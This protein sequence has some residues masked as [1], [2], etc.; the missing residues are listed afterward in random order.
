[1]IINHWDP[2]GV[3][4]HYLIRQSHSSIATKPGQGVWPVR[5]D[6]PVIS[7][8][9]AGYHDVPPLNWQEKM[10]WETHLNETRINPN[11][12]RYPGHTAG[13]AS[14][15]KALQSKAL[16]GGHV[17]CITTICA[18]IFIRASIKKGECFMTLNLDSTGNP[19]GSWKSSINDV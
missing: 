7:C 14:K 3:G 2:L 18:H 6:G 15:T 11:W 5:E 19:N 13:S 10:V 17:G 12:N 16:E 8:R 1:M 9:V 4:L